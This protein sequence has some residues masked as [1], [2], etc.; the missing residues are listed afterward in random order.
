MASSTKI[1]MEKMSANKETRLSVNPQAQEANSVM[2]SV[3][4][5]ARPTIKASRQPRAINTSKTTKAVAKVSLPISF[6]ALA[7]AVSP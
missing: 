1:P 5:T 6:F 3:T 4:E 7:S 2:M